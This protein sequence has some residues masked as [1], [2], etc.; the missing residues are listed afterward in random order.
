MTLQRFSIQ[1]HCIA[2]DDELYANIAANL[3]RKLPVLGQY[4][5]HDGVAVVVGS[6]P[7]V[8]NFIDDICRHMD[9]SHKI[10]AL[11]D[12]H[13]WLTSMNLYPDYAVAIDPQ[14]SRA[15][16]FVPRYGVNYF[17]ASQVHPAMLDHLAGYDVSL[18]HL[19]I[20]KGQTVPPP[21]TP[22]IAGGTTTGLRAITLFYTLGFR[23]FVLYGYDSCLKDGVLRMNGDK[24]RPGDD[25]INEIVVDG[26]TFYCN[27]SMTAQASEFQNLFWSMPDIQI[28]SYGDGI[29]TAILEARKKAPKTTVS[30]I[31]KWG[32]GSASYRYR[33][34]IPAEHL[35]AS[36]N[37][38]S[39]SV[40]I[41]AKPDGVDIMEV[42]KALGDGKRVIADFCDDHFDRKDYRDM[43]RLADEVTCS[44]KYMAE[45]ILAFGRDAHVIPEPY[46]YPEVE[47]HCNGTKLLWFGHASNFDST[48]DT[49][50]YPYSLVTISNH[51]HA[52][53]PWNH[54]TMLME[55][56]YADIVLMPA[57]APYKSCNRTVE[58]V[59]QG[60]FV[61]A[62]PHPSLEGFP[63][64]W[65]G[66]IKEG[67][68]WA[69][70]H[71]QEAN[72]RTKIAQAYISATYA[73]RT[74]AFAWSR[75]IQGSSSI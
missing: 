75:V 16:V 2:S 33:A 35:G 64:I 8:T 58:A 50:M 71:P 27:P 43:L 47:P 36:L 42:K 61:V 19:Y 54:E 70:Q 34:A 9:N 73:P 22:L 63:G 31:H 72:A 17:I 26:R 28:E 57:T 46:E 40:L 56:P 67:I 37:D 30:F 48:L 45:K 21:G 4:E 74:L 51:P 66:D 39:A 62:E 41:Y 23:K 6:G 69:R 14:Q 38:P 49:R 20:R 68:E 59:R 25:T 10:V 55:F 12:A 52:T 13:N 18:F 3:E 24:P 11:K 44:T 5:A 65:I 15:G 1:S 60:C 29:I 32:P 7:S 53:R